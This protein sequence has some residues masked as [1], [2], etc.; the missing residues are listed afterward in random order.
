MAGP[1]AASVGTTLANILAGLT[2][3]QFGNF[4]RHMT[5]SDASRAMQMIMTMQANPA[6]APALLPAIEGIPNLPP[7]VTTWLT[8][9]ISSP[10]N[11]QQDMAMATAALQQAMSQPGVLGNIGL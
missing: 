4:M 11:Y 9:A 7:A 6:M 10:A 5:Q 3:G 2:P 1:A 8:A